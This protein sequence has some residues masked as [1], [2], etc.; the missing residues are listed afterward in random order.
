MNEKSYYNK[1]E[2]AEV[3][4][5]NPSLEH[6]PMV[7]KAKKTF[8]QSGNKAL[9]VDSDS[10]ELRGTLGAVFIEQRDVDTEQFI[11]LYAGGIEELANLSGSGF[12][13]FKLVYSLMLNKHNSDVIVLN[14]HSLRI[15]N[16]WKWS[17]VTFTSGLN[18]L[19]KKDILFKHYT[20]HHYFYNV[21]YFFNGDRVS[22]IKAYKLKKQPDLLEDL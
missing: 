12:K 10:G 22:V 19:L 8:L 21:A 5:S 9:I 3:Y 6:L 4:S 1:L 13:V 18:E 17:N 11:K 16:K 20:P 2:E 15:E 14:Y 7:S